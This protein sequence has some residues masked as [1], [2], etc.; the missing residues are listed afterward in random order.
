M[1]NWNVDTLSAAIALVAMLVSAVFSAIAV[2]ASRK[3]LRLQRWQARQDLRNHTRAW[4]E[5]VVEVLQDGITHCFIFQKGLEDKATS[6]HFTQLA[7]KISELIDCGRWHFENDKRSGYGRWKEGAFQGLAP[8]AINILK[9]AHGH[10]V[11]AAK[12]PPKKSCC[13]DH[14]RKNL[15]AEKRAFVSEVQDFIQP[16]STMIELV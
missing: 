2:S 6:L 1:P 10:L 4:A 8:K 16:S 9:R 13:Y 7:G 12:N 3:Q 14:L 15:T 5:E 11:R